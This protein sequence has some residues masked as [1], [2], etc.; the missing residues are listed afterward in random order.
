IQDI[1]VIDIT[2]SGDNIL[3]LNLDDLLDASTSTNILKV[4]GNSGDE[5][6]ATG[7]D[8]STIDKI[9]NGITYDVYTHSDANTSAN[10]ELWVQKGVTTLDAKPLTIAISSNVSK[11]KAG[12]SA[13][14]TFTLSEAS[15]DFTKDDV[16]V[17]GGV[18]SDIIL[19]F[20]ETKV[21]TATFTPTANSATVGTISVASDKFSDAAGNTNVDGAD[22]N[23]SVFLTIDTKVPT[24][25]ISSDTDKLKVGESTT[26]TFTLSEVSA[27]FDAT[28]IVVTGGILTD[29]ALKANE[30]KVYTATF[31]PTANSATVG[32]ISVAS[33]K[34]SDA[35][36]NTNVDG[37]DVNNSVF[38][39]IDTKVP[40]I[41]ISSDTDKLKAG[42][43]TTITFT[44]S[45]VSADFDATDIVVTGGILT[46]FAL[47]ANETKVYTATFTPTANSATVGTISVASDK[48]SDAAGNTNVDGADVN[49]SVFLTIDT[50]APNAVDLD[51]AA[52]IQSTSKTLFTRSEISVGVAFDADIANTTNT[53]I[54]SIKVVLG[55]VGFNATNDKLILD[56][57]ITLRSDITAT[58][59]VIGTVA[60]L[61]YTYTHYSQT[62]I[63][64]KTSGTFAAEDV[65][66]VVEAIK[67][68]N[69][70]TDSQLGM[71]TATITY[72]DIVG[73]E[74]ASATASLKEAQRGFFINGESSG[75]FS[76]ISV[77]NAGDVNG[78]GLDDLIVGAL[79]A[80]PSSKLNAGKSYVV[81]GKQD[82]TDVIN[83]SA[84]AAGTG[85]FVINGES[86]GD[87]SGWSVSSA[88]DVNG[89]G[90][91]DL[92]VGAYQADPSNK[93][94]AGKSYVVFGKQNNTDAI[95]L[96][97]IAAGT[98]TGG[99][100]ING[101]LASD[102]SGRSVSSAGDVNGDGLD[103]LIVG[104]YQADSSNKS[105]AGK[106]YVVFGKQDNTAINL[107][108]IAAGTSTGGFVI[109]GES[110][111]DESGYSVSS[112][113][114]VNGDGLDDLIV[115]AYSAD[116]S[117][118]PNAGKS[119]VIFGKQD[120]TAI[121]L[122]A[123]V[124]GT[125]TDGFVINGESADDESGYSVSSAGDVNGDGLDD[126]I[127]GAY[128]A[129]LSGEPNAGKSYVIFGKQ[130]NTDAIN[131]SAIATGTST[132]GFVINGESEF[133]YNGHAVSS[134]GDVNGDGLDDLIVSADQAD[135]SGKPNAGK[136]YIIFGKQDNTAINLSIIVAGIGG[137]V[138]NGE[139]ASDYSSSVS[140]AG[141]VNG[142]GL[143]D[144]IVGA[145]Q[146]DP[147]GKTNAGKSYVIFGKTDTDAVDLSKLGDESKY[148]IDYL[149]NKDDN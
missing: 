40:T 106:S 80:D 126:L 10:A 132:G 121:N 72:M 127:V 5:V 6:I 100:V 27:D 89:D 11:L 48:F 140:S 59:K 86:M 3:K 131:L 47:K 1:E 78:D 83:L 130:D 117:G 31:T 46:D 98:S 84:I 147:S 33:D 129:D 142:D 82:N 136:S 41:A 7:F 57:D 122:S 64:S 96:S 88:G 123:I 70:D 134:A 30:T 102:Y 128:Q 42:E 112:A 73:N 116:P 74:S 36:G 105:N 13:T 95:N 23:N 18:L 108:A 14:I 20:G 115:G 67:L 114:D 38:L 93:S 22:V 107:S 62:L 17:L 109:N 19:K 35:A 146:A 124:A 143:D 79:Y 66:K 21:Y 63:I 91:D 68:K 69:T 125:S 144:L 37:A 53:D 77:S 118:K 97:A 25:A 81:F 71:R 87:H 133:N 2:G 111:D 104:A 15:P 55:G 148:T 12:E 141:D 110:A 34:F 135:P 101:E 120:N 39:T 94:N 9:V 138:I 99:F 45:E 103:D 60:G 52:D 54:K 58:N 61:E 50:K 113:G 137:F 8:D 85:G 119:Y 26:I 149:G 24:I 43:N 44:L 4:L 145:Y 16:S 56:T 75:D 139:S 92:I 29:F 76:G 28:D 49:N 32:T 65:A 51:P 90:L